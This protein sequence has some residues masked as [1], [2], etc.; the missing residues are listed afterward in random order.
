M[1]EGTDYSFPA[2]VNELL[3]CANPTCEFYGITRVD[4]RDAEDE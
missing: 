3:V 1:K 4:L 2:K